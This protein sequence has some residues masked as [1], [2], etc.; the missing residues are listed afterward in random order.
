MFS[1]HSVL[2]DKSV[3]SSLVGYTGKVFS[4][5]RQALTIDTTGTMVTL[6]NEKRGKGPGY[7]IINGFY[8]FL[9][10]GVKPGDKVEFEIDRIILDNSGVISL[11]EAIPFDS[12]IEF[13]PRDNFKPHYFS[14][15]VSFLVSF[16]EALPDIC[17][18][19]YEPGAFTE[20]HIKNPGVSQSRNFEMNEYLRDKTDKFMKALKSGNSRTIDRSLEKMVGLGEGLTPACD[21]IILGILG[22]LKFADYFLPEK[23]R[24][25]KLKI[26]DILHNLT[27][28]LPGLL[29][30]TTFVSASY[31]K[32]ALDNRYAEITSNILTCLFTGNLNKK[33]RIL[34]KLLEYG[35]SS[36]FYILSGIFLGLYAAGFIENIPCRKI[37]PDAC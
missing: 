37:F 21:D 35:A 1:D 31:L 10:P 13:P 19:Y 27:L 20:N 2:Y 33:R 25:D 11:K 9:Q 3:I 17:R 24:G 14:D 8:D 18:E 29:N 7:I 34:N 15:N 32:Y 6:L 28:S 4:L 5:H 30:K 26:K 36:G 16:Y 22:F 12:T 23:W